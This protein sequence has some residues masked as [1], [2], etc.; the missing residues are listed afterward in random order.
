M[1]VI[2][3]ATGNTGYVAAQK[4]LD[5]GKPVRVVS[6]KAENV[7]HF[8]RQGAEQAIGDLAD[9]AFV[10]DAFQ[11]ATA[12]YAVIPPKHDAED[13]RAYQNQIGE[14]LAKGLEANRVRYAVVLSSFGAHLPE[15]SGV[16]NGLYDF[17]Q[18]LQT[19]PE[20]NVLSLRAGF[21]FQNFYAT[22]PLI[23]N[24]NILG[25]FPIAPNVKLPMIHTTDIGEVASKALEALDFSGFTVKELAGAKDY[26]MQEAAG[27]IGEA[28][29]KPDLPYVAFDYEDAKQ[30]MMQ[31]GMSESLAAG[32]VTFSQAVNDGR[33][34][35]Q[36]Q[37]TLDNTTTRTLEAFAREDLALA[38]QE[39]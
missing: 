30:G 24:Q 34:Y 20:L 15:G 17:E 23:Q 12:V 36:Y 22:L 26:S 38:S 32:Y 9:P 11:D 16:V 37:R 5:A 27:I 3:G 19:I 4:L 28:L 29:G 2:T 39:A 10:Q 1:N 13:F 6:R 7:Q 31:M 33:L 14:N 25:G 21:F 8:V 18:R 35:E